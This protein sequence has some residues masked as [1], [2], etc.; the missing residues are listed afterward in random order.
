MIGS[1]SAVRREGR[2][3]GTEGVDD[4]FWIE[5]NPSPNLA[6]VLCPRPDG[7]LKEDLAHI[8]QS[9][10][11]TLV[12]LLDGEEAH[13]LGLGDEGRLAEE[14]GLRFL[15]YPILDVH[16]PANINTFREFVAGLADRLRAGERIG[17]HCRG[18]IGRAPLTAASTL[19]HLGW[20]ARDAIAAIQAARGYPV[21]DTEEQRRWILNYK[22]QA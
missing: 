15:S 4:V 18:S 10:V 7:G 16:V 3:M 22:A 9:G 2:F 11:E 13:W 14:V 6:I 12:S 5:G 17:M 21:P 8:Q 1:G 19:I 20:K